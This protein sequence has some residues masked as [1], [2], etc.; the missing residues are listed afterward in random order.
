MPFSGSTFTHLFDWVLDPQRQEKITNARLEAEFDGYDTGLSAVQASIDTINNTSLPAKVTGPGSATDNAAA[1]FDG[2]TGKL[3]QNSSFIIDDSGHIT[4]FGGNIAFPET[5]AASAAANVLDDYEEGTWTPAVAFGGGTTGITYS[6][7][8]GRYTKIG[9]KAFLLMRISL[10]AKGSSTG[11]ATVTGLPFTVASTFGVM[12]PYLDTSNLGTQ[13]LQWL[14]NTGTTEV[15]LR[16]MSAGGAL[17][18]NDTHFNNTT[19][20]IGAFMYQT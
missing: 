5:Q 7:Q 15:N 2:T 6:S 14:A 8:V 20:L 1:R 10:S 4:S 12:T 9:R 3:L 18:M 17:D 16:Y 19:L 13:H 11:A